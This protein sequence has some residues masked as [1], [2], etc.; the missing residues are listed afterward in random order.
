MQCK[1]TQQHFPDVV[2]DVF[3]SST[4]ITERVAARRNRCNSPANKC[5]RQPSKWQNTTTHC[6]GSHLCSWQLW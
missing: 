4:D 3:S 6:W 2:V 1:S 5:C